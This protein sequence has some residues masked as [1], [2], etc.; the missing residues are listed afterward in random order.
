MQS[1]AEAMT[2]IWL[3]LCVCNDKDCS[4]KILPVADCCVTEDWISSKNVHFLWFSQTYLKEG[5]KTEELLY[6]QAWLTTAF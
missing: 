1:E 3:H 2:H 5:N 6:I 4:F